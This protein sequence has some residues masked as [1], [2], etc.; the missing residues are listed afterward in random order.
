[1]ASKDTDGENALGTVSFHKVQ[2]PDL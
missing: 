1:M 2:S